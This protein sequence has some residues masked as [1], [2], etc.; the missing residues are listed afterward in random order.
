[1]TEEEKTV[2]A[3]AFVQSLASEKMVVDREWV[4]AAPSDIWKYHREECIDAINVA[5]LAVW[6]MREATKH[7]WA[8]HTSEEANAMLREMGEGSARALGDVIR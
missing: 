3:A 4:G 6:M 2:W 1:M 8:S 5:Y 7:L